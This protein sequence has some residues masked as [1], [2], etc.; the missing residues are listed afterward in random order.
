M[1]TRHLCRSHGK[2]DDMSKEKDSYRE[3]KRYNYLLG[4]IDAQYHEM[5]L[6]LG[7]SD[8]VMMILYTICDIGECC[9]LQEICRRSGISK[10]TINS[11]IRK[12]ERED[13][14]Y[15]ESAGAKNKSVCLTERGKALAEDTVIRIME[16]ENEI[17]A[18]WP[19]EDVSR[20]LDLTERFL[21]AIREKAMSMRGGSKHE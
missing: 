4:E 18:A 11:A 21:E 3:L 15:L 10:Q 5:S 7:L 12:M 19:E 2:G 8:S 9:L 1:L 13:I 17:F 14:V 6:K 16:A 20:Y